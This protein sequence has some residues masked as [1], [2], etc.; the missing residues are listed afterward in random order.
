MKKN[1]FIFSIILIILIFFNSHK[2]IDQIYAQ[3]KL[4]FM[5]KKNL[6]KNYQVIVRKTLAF[7]NHKIRKKMVFKNT[8]LNDEVTS[9]KGNKYLLNIYT[10]SMIKKKNMEVI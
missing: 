7:Y 10:N 6:P 9:N 2:I 1:I 8:L 4:I 3:K 5:Y